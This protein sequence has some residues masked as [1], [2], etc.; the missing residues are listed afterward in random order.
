MAN[1][2]TPPDK[3]ASYDALCRHLHDLRVSR[4]MH[5]A[6]VGARL[7]PPMR[8]AQVSGIERGVLPLTV[9]VLR[10]LAVIYEADPQAIAR[11]ILQFP[12]EER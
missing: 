2:Y 7:E 12:A 5:L 6:D 8:A 1:K 3:S 4:R 9:G 11:L 10:Q